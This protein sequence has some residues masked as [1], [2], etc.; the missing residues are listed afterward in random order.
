MAHVR[1]DVVVSKVVLR[2]CCSVRVDVVVS[3][4]VLV[5]GEFCSCGEFL[6]R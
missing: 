1:V 4:V 5:S 3:K 6:V 2:G